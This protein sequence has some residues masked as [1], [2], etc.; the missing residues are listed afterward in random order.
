MAVTHQ[1]LKREHLYLMFFSAGFYNN[2]FYL[3]S[4][5]IVNPLLT[6]LIANGS[7][8]IADHNKV[9]AEVS[10]ACGKTRFFMTST[11]GSTALFR[12]SFIRGKYHQFVFLCPDMA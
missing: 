11:H 12:I 4:S 9:F 6:T 1:F 3:L 10:R 2:C 8:P 7:W 5:L